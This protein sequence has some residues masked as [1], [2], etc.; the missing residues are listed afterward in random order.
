M[1]SKTHLAFASLL[2]T[3][4]VAS[5]TSSEPPAPPAQEIAPGK[6]WIFDANCE[7][8]GN[9]GVLGRWVAVSPAD[10]PPAFHDPR[11]ELHTSFCSN[12]V[13]Q[14]L[15]EMY[16]NALEE[17]WTF[18]ELGHCLQLPSG[19]CPALQACQT[20][21]PPATCQCRPSA[22][23]PCRS[24]FQGK[25][26]CYVEIPSSCPDLSKSSRWEGKWWSWEACQ[27]GRLP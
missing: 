20:I 1:A 11:F 15:T 9:P 16:G 19:L 18:P 7:D 13:N 5:E 27:M 6:R 4:I 25:P 14:H 23:G 2:V 21:K 12:G 17:V 10:C 24:N 26:F 22:K 3:I 8:P